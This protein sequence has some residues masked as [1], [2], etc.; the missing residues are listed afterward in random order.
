MRIPARLS[1]FLSHRWFHAVALYAGGFLAG[2]VAGHGRLIFMPATFFF[3]ALLRYT[4]TPLDRWALPLG[5]YGAYTITMFPGAAIFFGHEFNPF[6]IALLWLCFSALL[7]SPWALLCTADPIRLAWAVPCA[8]AL[9]TLPPIGL[10]AV[11]NPL[12]SAGIL[13]PH[14]RWIGL[15]LILLIAS[16]VATR[17][18]Y[19]LPLVIFLTLGSTLFIPSARPR[20]GWQAV[21]TQLGGQGLDV[22]D[23]LR[24]Y[25]TAQL[26]QRTALHS[27]SRVVVFPESIVQWNQS[28]E[29]FWRRTLATLR[30]EHR[31]L[32]VGAIVLRPSP[33]GAY[34]NVAVIRGQ[35][36]HIFDQR[37]PIPV[38]MWKILGGTGVRLNLEGPGTLLFGEDRA[39]IF[40]CYEQLLAWPM[41]MSFEEHPDIMVGIANDY[42][43]KGTYFPQIQ[44][45]NMQ[46]WGR[47]FN[48]PI[49]TA[50]NR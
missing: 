8:I 44:Q 1:I 24:D 43:A 30:A 2:L 19:A 42:W 13:F 35:Y 23:M 10:F 18:R 32:L 29:A 39:A 36:D 41:I 27:K 31:T 12:S 15:A 22:P 33:Q 25:S 45:A 21:N 5:Y 6:G 49:V 4:I 20:P 17:P 3:I 34:R 48:L 47:L 9:E 37:I 38:T 14:T 40:I 11:G 7:A 16:L 26:I 28:T 50:V 46:A